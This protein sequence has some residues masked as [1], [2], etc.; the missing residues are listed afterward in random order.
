M[1]SRSYFI[2]LL[3]S[4]ASGAAILI[5]ISGC[6]HHAQSAASVPQTPS[7]AANRTPGSPPPPPGMQQWYQS[8]L[9]AKAAAQR[10]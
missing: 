7:M 4:L 5:A 3:A 9:A 1:K 8:T 10:H 6:S 2:T